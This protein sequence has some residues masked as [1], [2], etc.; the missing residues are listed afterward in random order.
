MQL[1]LG[2]QRDAVPLSRDYMAVETGRLREREGELGL[3]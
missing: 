3:A 1:Q 2:H